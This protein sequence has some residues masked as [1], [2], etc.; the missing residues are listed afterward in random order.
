VTD[1]IDDARRLIE[2]RLAEIE[3]EARSLERAV[4]IL[5]EGSSSR[6]HRP[7]RRPKDATDASPPLPGPRHR[8]PRRRKGG[9]RAARGQRRNELLTAIKATPGGRPS[10]LAKAIGVRPTQVHALIAKASADKLIVKRG[11][12]YRLTSAASA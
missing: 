6:R 12:G 9:K 2:T 7:G 10:E 4:A 1:I 11:K 5:G 8:A 3:A